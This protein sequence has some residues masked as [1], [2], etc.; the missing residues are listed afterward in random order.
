MSWGDNLRVLSYSDYLQSVQG[1]GVLAV[2][3]LSL[4]TPITHLSIDAS[5][6]LFILPKVKVITEVIMECKP[7]VTHVKDIQIQSEA[8][9]GRKGMRYNLLNLSHQV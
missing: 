3:P 2:P 5:S 8:I 7:D 9:L 6:D 4:Q 1:D